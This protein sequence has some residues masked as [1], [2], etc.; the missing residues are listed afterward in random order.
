MDQ[1]LAT[2]ARFLVNGVAVLIV[3]TFLPGMKV[4][5]LRDAVLFSVVVAFFNAAA[6]SAFALITVPFAVVTLGVGA[7]I[8][9]AAVFLLADR[10]VSG[11]RISGWLSAAAGAVLVS[12]VNGGLSRALLG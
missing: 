11:V 8:V 10:V 7:L 1:L 5:R 2:V 6:W 12:L 3:A 9:N 4:D